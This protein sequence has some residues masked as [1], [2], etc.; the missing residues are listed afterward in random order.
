MTPRS[1]IGVFVLLLVDAGVVAPPAGSG[2]GAPDPADL[3]PRL[4]KVLVDVCAEGLQGR[5]VYDARLVRQ[6]V[7]QALAEELVERVQE[8]GQRFA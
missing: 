8:R 3:A 4:G 7:F 2:P 1:R 5:N 6:A